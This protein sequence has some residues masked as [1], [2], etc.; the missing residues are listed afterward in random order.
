MVHVAK[1]LTRK[2]AVT[3]ADASRNG[4]NCYIRYLTKLGFQL[5]KASR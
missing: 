2:L 1:A 5:R 3:K 4:V